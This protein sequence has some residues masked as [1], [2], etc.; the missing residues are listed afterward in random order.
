MANAK[1]TS[2]KPRLLITGRDLELL[3]SM[4]SHSLT[5]AAAKLLDEE[6]AR[7]VVVSPSYRGRPFCRIGSRVTY[8]DQ[9]SALTR[10]IRLVLPADADIDKQRV[11]VLSLVGVSLLGLTTGAQ[12]D[13]K[14]DG[15]RPHRLKVLDV[16]NDDDGGEE[17]D[18]RSRVAASAGA[19]DSLNA[20]RAA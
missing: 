3:E 18:A 9:N 15:G 7:A 1:T 12:F 14:D 16:V 20:E 17:N 6:L 13:W 10:E 5:S 11:S 2:G 8:E 19:A 4:L